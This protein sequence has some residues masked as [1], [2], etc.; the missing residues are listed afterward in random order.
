MKDTLI[1]FKTAKLVKEKGFDLETSYFYTKP[2][3]KMFGLDEE[4]RAYPIKNTAKKLYTCG[5]EAALNIENVYVAPTQSL[6]QKW[7]RE[8]YS[9]DVYVAPRINSVTGIREYWATLFTIDCSMTIST[10]TH[11][12]FEEVLEEGLYRALLQIP[13]KKINKTLKKNY[14]SK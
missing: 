13:D 4:G 5:E 7:L 12:S 14:G 3:S 11:K 6:L 2:N 8:I 10:D 9:I 1:T